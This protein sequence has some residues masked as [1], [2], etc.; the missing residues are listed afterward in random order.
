MANKKVSQL[1]ATTEANDGV[2]IIMNNSGNTE[3]FRI[4]REDLLSGTTSY[5]ITGNTNTNGGK[6]FSTIDDVYSAQP[7]NITEGGTIGYFNL[8]FNNTIN[9][10]GVVIGRDNVKSGNA[11]EQGG[12]IVG[13]GNNSNSDAVVFGRN[14]TTS[15]GLTIGRGI[16]NAGTNNFRS[17]AIGNGFSAGSDLNTIFAY[18]GGF[19]GHNH[20]LGH[21]LSLGSHAN[22][23][24]RQNV[25]TG[26]NAT[27]NDPQN[28]FGSKNTISGG[29]G[30]NVLGNR[31][32]ISSTGGYNG[33]FNS[34]GSVI[35]GTTSGTTLIGLK[36]F[37]SPTE[38]DTTYVD[39]L[40]VLGQ[41]ADTYFNN[42]SGDTFTIDWNEG[43]KQKVYMTGNTTLTLTNV[44]EGATYKLAVENGG[45]FDITSVSASGYT[46]LCEG[47]SI[48]NITNSGKD[49]CI[50]EVMGTDIYVR[51]FAGF[52][53]P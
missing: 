19:A 46:I 43:N 21:A 25:S 2:W 38:N 41:H 10:N 16:T 36:N 4:K 23:L 37:T 33:M 6:D 39:N 12:V 51:H 42:L 8:G 9:Q 3:T 35:S 5:A 20:A 27:E 45:S 26:A 48:P 44:R 40:K 13:W 53:A 29:I 15:R 22:S 52:A 47:G 49:L 34:P 31:Q 1:S 7:N 30:N 11:V 18:Q 24:G 17:L 50:L 14:N 32:T 28:L